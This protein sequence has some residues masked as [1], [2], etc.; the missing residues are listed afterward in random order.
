MRNGDRHAAGGVVR[1]QRRDRIVPDQHGAWAFLV[2]PI[3]LALVR[4]DWSWLLVPA[5]VSWVAAYPFSWALTGRLTAR[6]PER[7]DRALWVWL[8]VLLV[9][10]IPVLLARP[11]LMWVVLVYGALWVVNLRYASRRRERSLVNDVL[12]V[13]E[14]CLLIPVLV[15]IAEP[16]NGWRPPLDVLDGQMVLLMVACFAT[17]TGSVLH[18]KSLIRERND[19]RYARAAR[20][21]AVVAAVVVGL[22][23]LGLGRPAWAA[24]AF[25][26]FAT[27]CWWVPRT[28]RPARVGLVEMAGFVLVAVSLAFAS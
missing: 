25:L 20:E 6:R 12:L 1:P 5:A 9:P 17:L 11:W 28:W 3:V 10:G 18:V 8:P 13:V 21:F 26:V 16:S 14:C 27:R 15:G 23:A 7:F 2:L 22:V 24:L 4:A 19:A